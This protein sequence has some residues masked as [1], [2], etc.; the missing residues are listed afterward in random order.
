MRRN[1]LFLFLIVP[2]TVPAQRMSG[3][4]LL[5]HERSIDR[6]ITLHAHQI[7][8]TGGYDI[9]LLRRKF[10]QTGK[11]VNMGDEASPS[12]RH[13][14]S[15][16]VRYGITDN[17]QFTADIAGTRH[18][19]RHEAEYLTPDGEPVVS[20]Q[21]EN[22]YSGVRDLFLGVDLRAPFRSRKLD[23]ALSLGAYIPTARSA[24]RQPNHSFGTSTQDGSSIY[25]YSYRYHHPPGNG[26]VVGSIGAGAKY[27]TRQWAFSSGVSYR[28]GAKTGSGSEWKHQLTSSGE[29]EYRKEELAYRLPDA[30]NYFVEIEFQAARRVDIFINASG[31]TAYDGWI[32][33][34]DGLK[35]AVPYRTITLI[36]PGAEILLT[37]KLWLRERLDISLAGKNHE[38]ILSFQT[39]LMY[40][41]FPAMRD[42]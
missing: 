22:N 5:M 37:P 9:A 7:R 27:R 20:H 16:N 33:N 39:T 3:D 19:V 1:F 30:F 12:V 42:H 25:Q 32:S 31:F 28:H 34:A 6:P 24:S 10:D 2:L 36:S 15:L 35:V 40:N 26:I 13:D 14:Y 8:I 38:T 18:I 41:F 29:Y 17:I 4:S 23:I 21:V 11:T